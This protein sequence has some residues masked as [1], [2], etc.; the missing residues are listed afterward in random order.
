MTCSSG[1]NQAEA[2]LQWKKSF[3]FFSPPPLNSWSLSNINNLCNWTFITCDYTTRTVSEINLSNADMAGSIAQFNFTPFANL[4][5]FDLK[6]NNL[7]GPIPSAIATL[8]KL[9]VLDLSNN[10]FI[11]A[12]PLEIGLLT[13]LQYLNLYYNDLNGTIPPQVTNLPKVRYLNL[14]GNYFVSSESDW[15]HFLPMPCLTYLSLS[16]NDLAFEFPRF[17]LNFHNLTFLD[18]SLNHFSGPIPESLYTHLTKLE[19]L[20]LSNN[21]FQGPLSSNISNFSKLINLQLGAN[22]LNGSIPKSIGNMPYLETV[23]LCANLF[24]GNIPSSLGQLTKLKRL[25]LSSN[26][27]NSTIPSELG[28]CT[29]LTFLALAGNHLS[30]KLP[31]SLSQ[32]TEIT[33]LDLSENLLVGEIPSSVISNWTNLISLHLQ[34]NLFEGNI[35]PEIGLLTRLHHLLVYNNTLCGSIP[36]EIG[37]LSSLTNLGLS[38]N[39]LSGPIP[40]TLHLLVRLT[41]LDLSKNKL[42]GKIPKQLSNCG[43]LMGLNLCHNNLTGEIPSELGS[44]LFL[45]DLLDLS[46][47]SLSGSI[48]QDLDRLISLQN[49]NV[50]NNH[51]S[52]RIPSSLSNMIN[53]NSYD[54][55]NNELVGPIPS[56]GAFRDKN[57]PNNNAFAGNVGLCGDAQGL[58]PC[59]PIPSNS[60]PRKDKT[61]FVIAIIVSINGL[62]LVALIVVGVLIYNQ[63]NRW[64]NQVVVTED[65]VCVIWE[66][67]VT[68]TLGD[69]VRATEDFNENHCIGK[70]GSGKVYKAIL[71]A[72]GQVV[73]VKK[74]NMSE[75]E[76]IQVTNQLFENEIRMLMKV[77]HRNIVKLYGFYSSRELMYLVYEY[78]E[79]GSLRSMLYGQECAGEVLSWPTRLKIVRG[80]AHAIAYLHHH[81][82]PPIIHR[83]I[84]LNNILLESGFEPKLSDFGIA[85][86][87]NP[88][89]SNWT[90]LVGS[91]GYIAPELALTMQITE[92]CDI[93]SFGVVALEIMLGKH[94]REVLSS[95]SSTKEKIFLMDVLDQRMPPPTGLIAE[96]VVF[97]VTV[98]LACART[99]PGSRPPMNFVAQELSMR[100]QACLDEPLGTITIGML[101]GLTSITI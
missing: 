8:S 23:E 39:Q 64:P 10:S 68:F 74:L 58:S 47:N 7:E 95:L 101:A 85:R 62:I 29:N 93:Y 22:Q 55:S 87:L 75:S 26:R 34:D 5:C 42:I 20:N 80:L 63:R 76:R 18:L 84:S 43:K 69:I 81:C 9:L 94:P 83:D 53:L 25:V 35:P 59:K 46:S 48:P 99:K 40:P 15:S 14:G 65:D 54:F 4:T 30:G 66:R 82:S 60:G 32:L 3:Y 12:I 57:V 86:L 78:V 45:R 49:L 44:L 31:M 52:G 11:G 1:R 41:H 37:N 91:Y 97:A 100:T 21:A 2:L 16:F 50:S 92:K 28:S 89:S 96:Q 79:K 36:S 33:E 72:R 71:W 51:L 67:Q 98:G 61:R 90:L 27:F 70:G 77:R 17:I 24:Q 13:E 88:N 38:G 6:N 56:G 73:A 19:Y